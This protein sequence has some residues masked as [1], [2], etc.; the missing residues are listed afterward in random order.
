[1]AISTSQLKIAQ[2]KKSIAE[3]LAGQMEGLQDVPWWKTAG[4][5]ALPILATLALPG[6]GTALSGMTGLG[7]LG[8]ALSSSGGIGGILG[9]AKGLGAK[10]LYNY[11]AQSGT[12]GLLD[13]LDPRSEKDISLA[14]MS[15]FAQ[16]LG[17]EAVQKLRGDYL[18]SKKESKRASIAGSIMSALAQEG[19]IEALRKAGKVGWKP[20]PP[21]PYVPSAAYDRP[22]FDPSSLTELMGGQESPL[23]QL[24]SGGIG[25]KEFSE[26][27]IFPSA[28]PK[29]SIAEGLFQKGPTRS[30]IVN[31]SLANRQNALFK[32]TDIE[33]KLAWLMEM[34]GEY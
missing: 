16:A 2:K 30:S 28:M 5:V 3:E 29:P 9:T 33:D 18:S 10:S 20:K 15:P 22:Q 14:G 17:G 12:R 23:A 19:G 24:R 8:A 7:G 4:S 31:Q 11:L 25:P 27:D 26:I 34:K 1:M 13:V 6:I 32:N 21:L